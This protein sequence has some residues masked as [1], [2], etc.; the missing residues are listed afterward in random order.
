MKIE[1]HVLL[2][3]VFVHSERLRS[4]KQKSQSNRPSDDNKTDAVE[5]L[6]QS[7]AGHELGS[8]LVCLFAMAVLHALLAIAS[9]ISGGMCC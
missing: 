5:V 4:R 3:I 2:N 1:S 6:Q 9:A 8:L 7:A